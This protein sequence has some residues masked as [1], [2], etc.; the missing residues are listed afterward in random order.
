[1]YGDRVRQ[2]DL[3]FKK[4]LHFGSQRLTAGLDIYNVMNNSVTLA[5]NYT[6]S[7]DVDWL[8]AADDVHESARVPS[9]R[10]VGFLGRLN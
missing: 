4:I 5:Y 8:A 10:G 1:M 6:Y 2:L 3:S 7:P 9:E